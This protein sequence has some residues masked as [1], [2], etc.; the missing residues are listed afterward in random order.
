[1]CARFSNAI[2]LGLAVLGGCSSGPPTDQAMIANFNQHRARFEELRENICR[3]SHSQVVMLDPEWS[4]PAVSEGE[5]Q[6]YHA[7]LKTIGAKGVQA[8]VQPQRPCV[9]WVEF[10]AVG[11]I[12]SADYKKYRF[13]P[14]TEIID[15]PELDTVDRASDKIASYQRKIVGDWWLVFDHW[16]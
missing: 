5:K 12:G 4:K 11:G 15:R 6:N 2:Y 14:D 7:I 1:M 13:G 3:L 16:P 9:V 10:W 8:V